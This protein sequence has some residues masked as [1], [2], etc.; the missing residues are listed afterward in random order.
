MTTTNPTALQR[1]AEQ[2]LATTG[3]RDTFTFILQQVC[4]YFSVDPKDVLGRRNFPELVWPRQCVMALCRMRGMGYSAT[5]RLMGRDHGTVMHGTIKVADLCSVM[6]E[7]AKQF[8]DL[9]TTIDQGLK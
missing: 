7:L 5:G 3:N 2:L 8:N 1:R 6:P 4:C 9:K